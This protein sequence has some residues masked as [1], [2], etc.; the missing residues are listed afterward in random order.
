MGTI[1]AF[2]A[3]CQ[4]ETPGS[5]C[6]VSTDNLRCEVNRLLENAIAPNTN[7]TYRTGLSAF[8]KFLVKFNIEETWP[9]KLDTVVHFVAY[10]SINSLA[11]NT[12]QC[13]V[14][15]I[16]YKCKI[17]GCTDVTN[18]FIISKVIEGMKRTN[19]KSD[20]RLPITPYILNKIVSTLPA[21]CRN[22]F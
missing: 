17:L 11:A 18:N 16:A 5:T 8:E 7:K 14:S 10:L 12:A 22:I 9:P 13:Y 2:S 4:G 6:G 21:I 20:T 19:R 1:Q 3:R 15:A